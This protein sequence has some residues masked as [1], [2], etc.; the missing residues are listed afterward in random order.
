M[1]YKA[2]IIPPV[3]KAKLCF[4]SLCV[5]ITNLKGVCVREKSDCKHK[6]ESTL[7]FLNLESLLHKETGEGKS[8]CSCPRVNESLTLQATSQ[9]PLQNPRRQWSRG[10]RPSR[11]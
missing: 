6:T 5:G 9:N 3:K 2:P 8:S 1:D 4:D 7:R 10:K 11:R